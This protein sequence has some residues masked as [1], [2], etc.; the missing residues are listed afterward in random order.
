M[1]TAGSDEKALSLH[2]S[3]L[4]VGRAP[5]AVLAEDLDIDITPGRVLGVLG[6]SGVGKSTLLDTLEGVLPPVGG[7]LCY[8]DAQGGEYAPAGLGARLARVSQDLLLVGPSS[9]ESNVC[10]GRLGRHPWWRTLWGLPRREREKARALLE[11]FGLGALVWR[12][13]SGVSGGEQQRTAVARA[14]FAEPAVLL[15][16]E[17]TANLDGRTAERVLTMLRGHARRTPAVVVVVLHDV[18]LA[19]RFADDLLV[20]QERS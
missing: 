2:T 4:V 8:R 13:V 7:Q 3:S 16:D 18:R 9:L 1:S 14:L 12:A 19:E 11:E 17:P 6:P 5:D 15:A 20:L 10:L